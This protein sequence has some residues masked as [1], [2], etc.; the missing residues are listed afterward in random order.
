VYLQV[1][2]RPAYVPAT[3]AEAVR[4]RVEISRRLREIS[5]INLELLA[6]RSRRRCAMPRGGARFTVPSG[7][8]S[9]QQLCD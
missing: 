5:A 1:A 2:D 9:K 4:S 6:R 8:L 3:L 7:M